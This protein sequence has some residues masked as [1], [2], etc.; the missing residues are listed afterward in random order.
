MDI[1]MELYD[2]GAERVTESGDLTRL[3][4]VGD[5]HS[6]YRRGEALDDRRRL[7]LREILAMDWEPQRKS[8]IANAALLK[9]LRLGGV[10][11]PRNL[12][13]VL[14]EHVSKEE[15]SATFLSAQRRNTSSELIH[16][17]LTCLTDGSSQRLNGRRRL[18][19][20]VLRADCMFLMLGIT[21]AGT[22]VFGNGDRLIDAFNFYG[23]GPISRF[24]LRD[25]NVSRY[26]AHHTYLN[27]GRYSFPC[28]DHEIHKFRSGFLIG[29]V[30]VNRPLN[31]P[32][33][34]MAVSV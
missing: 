7:I 5:Q 16:L 29:Y 22:P 10:D 9:H 8:Q 20:R 25:R 11:H 4:E 14:L 24:F 27:H 18:E 17:S 6:E 26:L 28:Q 30:G 31:S 3:I 23:S 13:Q 34:A 19:Y 33:G 15:S 32:V 1:A 21:A 2:A 12:D